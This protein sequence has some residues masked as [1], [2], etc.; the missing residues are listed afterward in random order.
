MPI[1]DSSPRLN[2]LQVDLRLAA[3]VAVANVFRRDRADST[4]GSNDAKLPASA[5]LSRTVG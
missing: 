4:Q 5:R 2:D 3:V 1:F